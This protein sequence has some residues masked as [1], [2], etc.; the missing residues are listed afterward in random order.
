MLKWL[1]QL[2]LTREKLGRKMLSMA[3]GNH[4]HFIGTVLPHRKA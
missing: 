3:E 1:L 4:Y 2:E